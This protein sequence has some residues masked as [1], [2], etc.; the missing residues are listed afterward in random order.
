[1]ILCSTR[2]NY[3]EY[4]ESDCMIL[5]KVTQKSH[6]TRCLVYVDHYPNSLKNYTHKMKRNHQ[7]NKTA[8]RLHVYPK[9]QYNG[10]TFKIHIKTKLKQY[11]LSAIPESVSTV[12]PASVLTAIWQPSWNSLWSGLVGNLSLLIGV[13]ETCA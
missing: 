3:S 7:M 6:S 11:L 9:D 2:V 13:F 5:S 10:K 4:F 1:M 8:F 12:S